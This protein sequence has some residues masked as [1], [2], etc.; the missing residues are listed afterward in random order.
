MKKSY[1]IIIVGNGA[2]GS[3]TAIKLAQKDKNLS[4]ALVGNQTRIGSASAAAGYMLNLFSELE[5]NSLEKSHFSEKRFGMGL[6]AKKLW[7]EWSSVLSELSQE[8]IDLNYGTYVINNSKATDIDDCNFKY[9]VECLKKYQNPYELLDPVEIVGYFPSPKNRALR[10]VYIPDEGFFESNK[11]FLAFD[12]ILS[13]LP[14]ITCVDCNAD[15]IEITSSNKIFTLDNNE[16]ITAPL[17]LL[18]AGAFTQRLVDQIPILKMKVPRVFFGTGAGLQVSINNE[19]PDFSIPL[20]RKVIRTT[21]RG[22]ACGVHLVPYDEKR[23]YI[24]ASNLVT[25]YYESQPRIAAIHALLS[26][27]MSELNTNF[28]KANFKTLLGH[29]PTSAD[30]YPILGKTSING[31]WLATG[32]K[33]DG[34][35]LSPLI[36]EAISNEILGGESCL[37]SVFSPERELIYDMTRME[38]IEKSTLHFISSSYQHDFSCAHTGMD[39]WFYQKVREDIEKIYDR[40]EINVG[41]PPELL[42]MYKHGHIQFKI[43]EPAY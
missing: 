1:D 4:I 31:L 3:S 26:S 15:K 29:R 20:P 6:A 43:N 13:S 33:R 36:S 5:E 41:I 14:N 11:I 2:I 22:N 9:I 27:A 30:V 34:F 19:I 10:A 40:L 37:P 35:F 21:N 42:N 8:K 18:C 7:P 25:K 17:A 38:G 28:Y 12:K 39:T 32:T 24:G 16:K 23:C